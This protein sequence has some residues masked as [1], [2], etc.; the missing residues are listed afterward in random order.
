[1]KSLSIKKYDFSKILSKFSQFILHSLIFWFWANAAEL[2]VPAN[3]SPNIKR[4]S[5]FF[6]ARLRKDY[7]EG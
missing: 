6:F 5:P 2:Y 1:M 3:I 4:L 7:F